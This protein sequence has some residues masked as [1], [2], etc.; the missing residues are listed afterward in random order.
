MD[1]LAQALLWIGTRFTAEAYLTSTKIQ[2][3]IWS[4]A[5]IVLLFA[6]LRIAGV[7]RDREGAAPVRWRYII[8]AGT[9]LITPLLL[10]AGTSRQIIVLESIIC[11]TQFLLIIVTILLERSRFLGLVRD[12]GRYRD[13]G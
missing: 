8:L 3:I 10:F 6:F 2:G 13:S 12:L 7:L 9:A 5:D 1:P 11:G 4:I